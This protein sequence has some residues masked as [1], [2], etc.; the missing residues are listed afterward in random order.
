MDD[1]L[2]EFMHYLS[3]WFFPTSNTFLRD[4]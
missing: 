4:R 1:R 3:I 2:D